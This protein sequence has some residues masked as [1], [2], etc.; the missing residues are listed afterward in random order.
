MWEKIKHNSLR[1]YNNKVLFY[2]SIG[3]LFCF[4]LFLFFMWQ[5]ENRNVFEEDLEI[6]IDVKD[7]TNKSLT[8][9]VKDVVGI[10]LPTQEE[11]QMLLDRTEEVSDTLVIA[12][13]YGK[14]NADLIYTLYSFNALISSKDNAE[15]RSIKI[16]F[17]SMMVDDDYEF[18]NV[19]NFFTPSL[20]TLHLSSDY[21]YNENSLFK[22]Y[23]NDIYV[24]HVYLWYVESEDLMRIYI[25]AYINKDMNAKDIQDYFKNSEVSLNGIP[26]KPISEEIL[27]K[28]KDEKEREKVKKAMDK[29]GFYNISSDKSSIY[30]GLKYSKTDFYAGQIFS[31]VYSVENA[32]SKFYELNNDATEFTVILDKLEFNGLKS[33]HTF[34][35]YPL[36][37]VKD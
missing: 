4:G 35:E 1:F 7:E 37:Y 24:G 15:V 10:E 16:G 5:E 29:D 18:K 25:P 19:N 22:K 36:S 20:K 12:N 3:L 30:T 23:N 32:S 33:G 27:S 6:S 34:R 28:V 13:E 14:R 17:M 2:C 31:F 8:K 26:A 21:K 9:D 11:V